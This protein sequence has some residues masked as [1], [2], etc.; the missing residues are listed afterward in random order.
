MRLSMLVD[1][2]LEDATEERERQEAKENL[3]NEQSM[4]AV[5]VESM[6]S[7]GM[8][9]PLSVSRVTS[10]ESFKTSTTTPS[11]STSDWS[12]RSSTNSWETTDVAFTIPAGKKAGEDQEQHEEAMPMGKPPFK[13]GRVSKKRKSKP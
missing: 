13:L 12:G 1:K 5:R 6:G 10:V 7:M 8:G 11:T 3:I 2:P 4:S 9:S